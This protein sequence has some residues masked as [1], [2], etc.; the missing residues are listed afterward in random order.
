MSVDSPV[1][2][3]KQAKI[4]DDHNINWEDEDDWE[5][6]WEEEEEDDWEDEDWYKNN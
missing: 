3:K 1:K 6:D 2:R 4:W 5:D